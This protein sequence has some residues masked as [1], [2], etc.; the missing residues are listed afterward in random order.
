MYFVS[1][2]VLIRMTMPD[3]YTQRVVVHD[4][5]CVVFVHACDVVLGMCERKEKELFA[6]H[7]ETKLSIL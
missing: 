1:S 6:F 7:N 4:E 5:L 2:V 3:E